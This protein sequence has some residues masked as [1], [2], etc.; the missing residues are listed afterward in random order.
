MLELSVGDA[1]R[2]RTV[3][4]Y[5]YSV[6]LFDYSL[7]STALPV[8]NWVGVYGFRMQYYRISFVFLIVQF[9]RATFREKI[10][11]SK[12]ILLMTHDSRVCKY[13]QTDIT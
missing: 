1:G 2:L 7:E 5:S 11:C 8:S 4:F 10:I 6:F 3:R 12:N 13:S 9:A